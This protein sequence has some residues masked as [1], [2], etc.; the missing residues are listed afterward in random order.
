[1]LIEEKVEYVGRNK[2]RSHH[3][4]VRAL[5]GGVK[6]MALSEKNTQHAASIN[7][8]EVRKDLV[9]YLD[10]YGSK[11]PFPDA[12]RPLDLKNLKVVAFVQDD[13]TREILQGVQVD[14]TGDAGTN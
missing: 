2:L 9:K 5:P 11:K 7:L 14:I 1:V 4:V 3:H 8:D 10:D 12:K 6:G 13:A